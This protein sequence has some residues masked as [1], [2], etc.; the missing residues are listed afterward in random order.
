[1]RA[2]REAKQRQGNCLILFIFYRLRKEKRE[3]QVNNSDRSVYAI[4][5]KI[6]YYIILLYI[7]VEEKYILSRF[8]EKLVYNGTYVRTRIHI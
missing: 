8:I 1:M 5:A 3:K 2:N 4:G 6:L 7:N